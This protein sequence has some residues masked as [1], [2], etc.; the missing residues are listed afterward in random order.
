MKKYLSFVIILTLILISCKTTDIEEI[1]DEPEQAQNIYFRNENF[2]NYETG[3]IGMN[4]PLKTF[5]PETGTGGLNP[6]V[7]DAGASANIVTTIGHDGKNT[8][9]LQLVREQGTT[10]GGLTYQVKSVSEAFEAVA[11]IYV[12]RTMMRNGGNAI[13]PSNTPMGND[14]QGNGM[15]TASFGVCRLDFLY[16]KIVMQTDVPLSPFNFG[17]MEYYYLPFDREWFSFTYIVDIETSTVTVAINDEI[18]ANRT[19]PDKKFTMRS[20]LVANPYWTFDC[21]NNIG[22]A[23]SA[24]YFDETQ[25]YTVGSQG[26]TVVSSDSASVTL[27]FNNPVKFEDIKKINVSNAHINDYIKN[28]KIVTLYFS[29]ELKLSETYTINAAD[30]CDIYGTAVTFTSTFTPTN[31]GKIKTGASTLTI[32]CDDNMLWC[33]EA[34][35]LSLTTDGDTY[36][37]LT[38]SMMFE[39]SANFYANLHAATVETNGLKWYNLPKYPTL[40]TVHVPKDWTGVNE[41]SFKIYSEEPT[42]DIIYIT[43]YSDD[44]T[45]PWKDAFIYPITID[46]KG[47]RQFNIPLEDFMPFNTPYG[48]D[49][50]DGLFFHSKIFRMNPNPYTV[51]YFNDIKINYNTQYP[52]TVTN[53]KVRTRDLDFHRMVP[54]YGDTLNHNYPETAVTGIVTPIN[55]EA[56]YKTERALLG[57]YPKYSPGVASF[58]PSGKAYIKAGSMAHIQYLNDEGKWEVLNLEPVIDAYMKVNRLSPWVLSDSGNSEEMTIRFD[59]DG[60][61]YLLI[62]TLTTEGYKGYLMY[63][64]D[65]METWQ[66][67]PLTDGNFARM[68]RIE[69]N[70][71][72]AME[73]PPLI[74]AHYGFT[75]VNATLIVPQKTGDGKLDLSKKVQYATNILSPGTIHSGDGNV[76]ISSPN[77]DKVYI[78][79]SVY[80][81]YENV[82]DMIPPDHPA[83]TM[84]Y[85]A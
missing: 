59:T 27:L 50:I 70:N 53:T 58:D 67:Y 56:Y 45:S 75:P 43:V 66:I 14:P 16:G 30:V 40:S 71:T 44:H 11:N 57:Y 6:T 51:V 18:V 52:I 5:I 36:R 38:P 64:P 34:D 60:G 77:G 46:F 25:V 10:S 35:V 84:S 76:M 82:K 32:S 37:E 7:F 1:A 73:R 4:H 28:G 54:F 31:V 55:Y 42:G 78:I 26:M 83:L 65:N 8:K 21:N 48:W 49:K 2:E 81:S 68:E 20:L 3:E 85:K 74:I 80:D 61:V 22:G 24:I 47:E 39:S 62:N 72:Y 69:G 13:E 79:Y 63:S 41:L 15:N 19:Y 17:G 9:A 12:Y 29:E 33:T 23:E